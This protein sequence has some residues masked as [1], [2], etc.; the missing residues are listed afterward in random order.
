MLLAHAGYALCTHDIDVRRQERMTD[1]Y[2][3]PLLSRADGLPIKM[4]VIL[5]EDVSYHRAGQYSERNADARLAKTNAWI[6]AWNRFET[7]TDPAWDAQSQ[8]VPPTPPAGI[9]TANDQGG[10]TRDRA[11]YE[12]AQQEYETRSSAYREQVD[13]R[14]LRP[15]F[16]QQMSRFLAAAYTDGPAR[17]EELKAAVA[18]AAAPAEEK[19]QVLNDALARISEVQKFREEFRKRWGRD[20]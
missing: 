15:G 8:P 14:S 11:A 12:A 5:L 17:T 3:M 7:E 13:L 4:E 20:P 16:L 19:A 9:S 2:L 18:G 10:P 1:T 6:H